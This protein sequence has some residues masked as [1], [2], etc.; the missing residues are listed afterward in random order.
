LDRLQPFDVVIVAIS[1]GLFLLYYLR[2]PN[3]DLRTLESELRSRNGWEHLLDACLTA[4]LSVLLTLGS[5]VLGQKFLQRRHALLKVLADASYWVYLVHLPIVLFLQTL[6]IPL[7]LP[8]PLK[9]GMVLVGTMLPCI[10]TYFVFVRYT[11]LGW[12]LHG[13]RTFP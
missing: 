13:K 5:L 9:L 7:A 10:A 3:L 4:Y 2:M 1:S 6:L 11:P 8:V 12:L